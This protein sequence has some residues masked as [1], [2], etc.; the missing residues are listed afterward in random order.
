MRI[1]YLG[2][3]PVSYPLVYPTETGVFG[4]LG[5]TTRYL[6]KNPVSQPPRTQNSSIKFL[7]RLLLQ[8]TGGLHFPDL[9]QRVLFLY[10]LHY[11]CDHYLFYL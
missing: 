6:G 5:V 8:I 11:K 4:N 10:G 7:R 1:K 3:N 9:Y 2:K